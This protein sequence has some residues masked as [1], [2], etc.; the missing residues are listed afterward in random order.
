MAKNPKMGN[1]LRSLVRLA[2]NVSDITRVDLAGNISKRFSASG[3]RIPRYGSACPR[4]NRL[5]ALRPR[6]LSNGD[7]T[8]LLVS[9]M[10]DNC[11]KEGSHHDISRYSEPVIF[12]GLSG[13]KPGSR[14]LNAAICQPPTKVVVIPLPKTKW[15]GIWKVSCKSSDYSAGVWW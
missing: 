1:K 4:L 3:M 9:A 10:F 14:A 7:E 12:Q 6:Q 15:T 2:S 11:I 5:S 13:C 8:Y